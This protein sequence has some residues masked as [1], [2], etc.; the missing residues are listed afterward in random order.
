[1]SRRNPK[2]LFG[3]WTLWDLNP[4][5]YALKCDFIDNLVYI[6][7]IASSLSMSFPDV[8]IVKAY[9]PKSINP[10]A[11][12]FERY[13]QSGS[14]IALTWRDFNKEE[15]KVSPIIASFLEK[16]TEDFVSIVL[17]DDMIRLIQDGR[18]SLYEIIDGKERVIYKP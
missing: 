12:K 2:L 4:D 17:Y 3:S 13:H 9:E 5:N 11:S 8:K 10:D 15:T 14:A 6:G 1:M 16:Q 18:G 7:S